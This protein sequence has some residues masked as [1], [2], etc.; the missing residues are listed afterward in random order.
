MYDSNINVLNSYSN[1][2]GTYSNVWILEV[3]P[4]ILFMS[5]DIQSS[6][7]SGSYSNYNDSIF[8]LKFPRRLTAEK[9]NSVTAYVI[10]YLISSTIVD[11]YSY[12]N[13]L[14]ASG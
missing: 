4:N 13:P 10:Y 8:G 2:N 1:H 7:M 3:A 5:A 6:S 14:I 11:F 12:L 9:L